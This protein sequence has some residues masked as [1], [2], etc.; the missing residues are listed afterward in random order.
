MNPLLKLLME[1]GRRGAGTSG[2]QPNPNSAL[3][4]VLGKFLANRVNADIGYR[5]QMRQQSPVYQRNMQ[6]QFFKG[7][8]QWQQ[9]QTGVP[10]V[11]K[12]PKLQF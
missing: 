3:F 4:A 11:P 9:G 7:Y 6:N 8:D 12:P 1:R 5:Q 2:Y 10:K